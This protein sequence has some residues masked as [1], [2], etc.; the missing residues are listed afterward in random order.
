MHQF[1]C[2]ESYLVCLTYELGFNKQFLS[3]RWLTT[4]EMYLTMI[5]PS[6]LKRIKQT[7]RIHW[8]LLLHSF[9]SREN[10]IQHTTE[11]A[12]RGETVRSMLVLERRDP[13]GPCYYDMP[14]RLIKFP[15]VHY[16]YYRQ[17]H[18]ATFFMLL[19]LGL[20]ASGGRMSVKN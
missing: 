15:G 16:Y 14:N 20:C 17:K 12:W 7:D 11:P 5:S 8:T 2:Q 19:V 4:L 9:F 13:H 3:Q 1:V 6:Q 10:Q 18:M